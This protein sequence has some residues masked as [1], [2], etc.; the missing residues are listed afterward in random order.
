MLE[1]LF[2][3]LVASNESLIDKFKKYLDASNYDGKKNFKIW[4][5]ELV[6][7]M[8]Q[9]EAALAD[10]KNKRT[11]MGRALDEFVKAHGPNISSN[12]AAVDKVARISG[13]MA[14]IHTNMETI[15]V[16]IKKYKA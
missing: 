14:D 3:E 11:A 12:K 7:A 16:H 8:D 6:K 1:Q 2:N 15:K 5:G 13:V 9:L 4:L 10:T